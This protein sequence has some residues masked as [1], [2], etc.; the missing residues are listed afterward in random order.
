MSDEA[1][2][3][4]LDLIQAKLTAGALF[5][6]AMLAGYQALLCSSHCLYLTEPRKEASRAFR[7]RQPSLALSLELAPG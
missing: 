3:P 2:K 5:A 1:H 6:D 7:H 4:F